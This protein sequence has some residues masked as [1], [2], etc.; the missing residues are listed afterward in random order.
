MLV[1]RHRKKDDNITPKKGQELVRTI[2]Y[3]E[4]LHVI[5]TMIVRRTQ[6]SG[7]SGAVYVEGTEG[8]PSRLAL[9]WCHDGRDKRSC[10]SMGPS[11]CE[12]K[13]RT[14]TRNK[15]EQHRNRDDT[16]SRKPKQ[17]VQALFLQQQSKMCSLYTVARRGAT[18]VCYEQVCWVR[19]AVNKACHI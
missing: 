8:A 6:P 3:M 9:L 12:K 2:I 14:K 13:R 15:V 4:T 16:S 17:F 18:A 11:Y 10:Q 7:V 19:R 1:P 5:Y